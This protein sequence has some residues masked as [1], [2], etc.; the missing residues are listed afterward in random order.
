MNMLKTV[1]TKLSLNHSIGGLMVAALLGITLVLPN[2]VTAQSCS[3]PYYN[4][5]FPNNTTG[6]T[7]STSPFVSR[8]S[9]VASSPDVYMRA[10]WVGRSSSSVGLN[11]F[12]AT[13]PY[14][15]AWQPFL[16]VPATTS[17]TDTSWAEFIVEF[18]SVSNFSSILTLNCLAITVV[19]CDGSGTTS[20]S[21][22]HY[23]EMVQVIN[24]NAINLLSGS[25]VTIGTVDSFET[26]VSD[27]P[28]FNNIDTINKAAMAQIEYGSVDKIRLRIA[29]IGKRGGTTTR[30]FSLHFRPYSVLTSILPVTLTDVNAN[31]NSRGVELQWQTMYE[32][33]C[34]RFVVYKYSKQKETWD[35]VGV[36]LCN[37]VSFSNIS[38]VYQ[39]DN[40][41]LGDNFYKLKQ[42]DR[43]GEYTWSNVVS[44]Y[45]GTLQNLNYTLYPNPVLD[46]L[47]I[48]GPSI[49]S[50]EVLDNL[51]RKVT[52]LEYNQI[53]QSIHASELVPGSYLIVMENMRGD[54]HKMM[55]LKR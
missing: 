9:Q 33:M 43:N 34:N 14:G 8:I 7:W 48:S 11:D 20:S 22:S 27:F 19:D 10:T 37:E 23:R 28:V 49:S 15:F 41:V 1:D 12:D 17:T 55:F 36:N 18:S 6:L 32:Q 52:N 31:V 54:T 4:V 35:S 50:I 45:W 2:Y 47:Y 21:S 40:P 30:Q 44:A 29:V 38:Y 16:S 25:N 53:D 39:D 26:I 46:K 13:S 51:G 42:I 3:F 5:P 24:P